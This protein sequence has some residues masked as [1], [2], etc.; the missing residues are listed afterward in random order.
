M[1]ASLAPKGS[2][3]TRYIIGKAIGRDGGDTGAN[4]AAARWGEGS[5][6]ARLLKAA[7]A[8]G[9]SAGWGAELVSD[10][11]AAARE[12]IDLVRAETI[13]G[14]LAGLRRVPLHTPF[15]AV[16]GGTTGA[17][18]PEGKSMP[19]SAMSF[20]RDSLASL[21]VA[22]A[23]V[24]TKELLERGDPE[25]EAAIRADL[26]S[27]VALA[28]DTAF[29]DPAN[30]GVADEQP[31]AITNG[32]T[33]V[34]SGGDFGADLER[35]TR[36]FQGDLT[37]AFL[38]ARPEFYVSISGVLFP[39]VG[40]RGGE[41]AG[42]PAIASRGVPMGAGDTYQVALIDPAG[43]VYASDPAGTEIKTS[44]HGAIQMD[45]APTNDGT[46][47]TPTNL[48]SLWQ[49]NAVGIAALLR[50]NWQL[51]RA[52]SVAL[53]TEIDAGPAS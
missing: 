3:F 15:L 33:P 18:V 35:L 12:F 46:T 43:V 45:D 47:P 37:K 7:V 6:P 10:Y 11:S 8:G 53:L 1:T 22:A 31:A 23:T 2:T 41:V 32:V 39:N 26:V 13:I 34:V 44:Q 14:R 21:K 27:A 30:A 16:T 49:A 17:W 51:G 24:V 4:F 38:V 19:I 48:V 36:V 20:A 29:I 42:I 9:T 28:S 50:E 25:A 52:G 40:A 5:T